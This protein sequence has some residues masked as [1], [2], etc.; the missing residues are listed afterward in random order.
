[1]SRKSLANASV[2]CRFGPGGVACTCCNHFNCHPRTF[3]P[4]MRR[5]ER[6]VERMRLRNREED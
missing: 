1:M 2:K 4:L 3:K 5:I 6:R